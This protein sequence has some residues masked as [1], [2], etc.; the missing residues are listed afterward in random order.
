MKKLFI[1]LLFYFLISNLSGQNYLQKDFKISDSLSGDFFYEPL[2][3]IDEK[4]NFLI[5]YKSKENIFFELLDHHYNRLI[6]HKAIYHISSNYRINPQ[7][8]IWKDGQF[9]LFWYE[10]INDGEKVIFQKDFNYLG[11]PVRDKREIAK[12]DVR[13]YYIS[14]SLNTSGEFSIIYQ[15]G[16]KFYLKYLS[17]DN[18]AEADSTLIFNAEK[19]SDYFF[20]TAGILTNKNIVFSWVDRSNTIN[21][22]IFSNHGVL[23]SDTIKTESPSQKYVIDDLLTAESHISFSIIWNQYD[24]NEKRKLYT[25]RFNL[26]GVKLGDIIKITDDESYT[27]NYYNQFSAGYGDNNQMVITWSD[28]G[29]HDG[30]EFIYLQMLDKFGNKTGPNTIATSVN[31]N[32]GDLSNVRQLYP[33][34][35]F[36]K[37][38]IFMVWENYTPDKD[39]D[40]SIYMNGLNEN[41]SNQPP[42]FTSEIKDQIIASNDSFHLKLPDYY[43]P[44][45]DKVILFAHSKDE[46][47]LPGWVKMNSSTKSIFGKPGNSDIGLYKIYIIAFDPFDATDT[48]VFNLK[49]NYKPEDNELYYGPKVD[50][51]ELYPYPVLNIHASDTS[52]CPFTE[53]RLQNVV[54]IENRNAVS[55][56]WI[57][58]D[59]E[60]SSFSGNPSL[61]IKNEENIIV[62][63][64]DQWLCQVHDTFKINVLDSPEI[65]IASDDTL[66][67]TKGM[68]LD[69]GNNSYSYHW[70]TGDKSASIKID[71]PGIYMLEATNADGCKSADSVYITTC[72][73]INNEKLTLSTFFPNPVRNIL[74]IKSYK[75]INNNGM[76]RIYSTDGKIVYETKIPDHKNEFVLDLSH[77]DPGI[78]QIILYEKNNFLSKGKIVVQ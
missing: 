68:I 12:V 66:C 62:E 35:K 38:Q 72:T 39:N 77:L 34:V 52:V 26:D 5:I 22:L 17:P 25:Q 63:V 21:S 43:D 76:V 4:G 65:D 33:V 51:N 27:S 37:N 15:S 64:T 29:H 1:L 69:A 56:N 53:I 31:K 71:Q 7:L 67:M 58:H 23:I 59:V 57:K 40:W 11:E 16:N 44:N 32:S 18:N 75:K 14:K 13:K 70:N 19:M 24:E 60:D 3:E 61:L 36:Y 20:Y 45:N 48:V 41:Q 55:Y 10:E 50:V 28:I 9:S 47:T 6:R 46:Q 78:Y 30:T 42:V 49:V 2:I 73:G 54:K 74:S 8:R